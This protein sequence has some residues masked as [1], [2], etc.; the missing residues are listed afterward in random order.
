M[1][2]SAS[3]ARGSRTCGAVGMAL[4]CLVLSALIGRSATAAGA[5]R[6]VAY[7][8]S[9]LGTLGGDAAAFGIDNRGDAVGCAAF[10]GS[11]CERAVLYRDG[12]VVDLGT[13]PG[14]DVSIARAVND[15]GDVVGD[16]TTPTNPQLPSGR[17]FLF[18]HGQMR[19]LG[20]LGG[21]WSEAFGINDAGTVIGGSAIDSSYNEHA[22]LY[23]NGT[24][25]DINPVGSTISVAS[26]ISNSGVTV[27]L[28]YFGVSG[29]HAVI[30]RNGDVRVLGTLGGSG[31]EAFGVNERGDV[32]GG[33]NLPG[34]TSAHA[35]LYRNGHMLDLGSLGGVDGISDA[36]AINNRGQVVGES[37]TGPGK[38]ELHAFLW[39]GGE[40]LDL[41]DLIP[42][43]SGWRLTWATGIN[44]RGQITGFGYHNGLVRPFLLQPRG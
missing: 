28:G 18:S 17:A 44:D 43:D 16:S 9:D 33:A 14:G 6:T 13:L 27:G 12:Q 30:W 20:T 38:S 24:M 35:F 7:S 2:M 32:V 15:N 37:G 29:V 26:A 8:I 25:T 41:N 36:R 11:S 22:F 34:D 10:S 1:L 42:G 4:V 23:R 5:S 40:M 3:R 31:S 19:D 21:S 39:N